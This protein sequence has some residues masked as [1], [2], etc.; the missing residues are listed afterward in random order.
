MADM[1]WSVGRPDLNIFLVPE[2]E[3]LLWWVFPCSDGVGD[4]NK[5]GDGSHC[6]CDFSV[7]MLCFACLGGLRVEGL[8]PLGIEFTLQCTKGP[9]VYSIKVQFSNLDYV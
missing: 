3:E 4:T 1:V 5:V 2:R 7:G 6:C 8:R 9:H